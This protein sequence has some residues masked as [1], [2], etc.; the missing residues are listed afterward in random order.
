MN[1]DYGK[2][3]RLINC[4]LNQDKFI[5]EI[6]LEDAKI[7]RVNQ[8]VGLTYKTMESSLISEEALKILKNDYYQY[9]RTDELQKQMIK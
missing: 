8:L 1:T 5:E 9:I 2:F 3:M 6:T 7:I 4:S